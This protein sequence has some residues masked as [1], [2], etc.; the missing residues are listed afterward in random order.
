M[1]SV[2]LPTRVGGTRWVGHMKLAMETFLKGYEAFVLHLGQVNTL[3]HLLDSLLFGR[4]IL[5]KF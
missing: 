5:F 2:V 4:A 1:K 3:L